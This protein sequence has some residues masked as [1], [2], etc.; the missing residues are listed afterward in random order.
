MSL[1]RNSPLT[2]RLVMDGM[3]PPV[4]KASPL[5]DAFFA[6]ACEVLKNGAPG[7]SAKSREVLAWSIARRCERVVETAQ[8]QERAA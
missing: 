5:R 6:N 8:R 1:T 7:L 4:V 3:E 2:Q